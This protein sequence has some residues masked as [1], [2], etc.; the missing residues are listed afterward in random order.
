VAQPRLYGQ[1]LALFA[2]IALVLAALG[3]YGVVS[4]SVTQRT[5]ELGVRMAL[6]AT[7]KEILLLV[8]G[9]SMFFTMLGVMI[10]IGGAL[11][12][13]RLLGSL[14]FEIHPHDPGTLFMAALLLSTVAF[15]AAYVPAR[16]ASLID[17]NRALRV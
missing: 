1:V 2:A 13:T 8:L 9:Q 10:G 14:L 12:L 11:A 17:P 6:G 4:Y 3:I 7:R 5:R 15:I 16:R